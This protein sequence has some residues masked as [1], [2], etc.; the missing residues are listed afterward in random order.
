M[1]MS[2][3]SKENSFPFVGLFLLL[4]VLIFQSSDC[5]RNPSVCLLCRFIFYEM[6]TLHNEIVFVFKKADEVDTQKQILKKTCQLSIDLSNFI[7]DILLHLN[8]EAV[9]NLLALL[10][11]RIS[12]ERSAHKILKSSYKWLNT[13]GRKFNF[14]RSHFYFIK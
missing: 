10:F 3:T 8:K 12:S 11:S 13:C 7:E 14:S 9:W 2:E 5:K 4:P 6:C 1:T